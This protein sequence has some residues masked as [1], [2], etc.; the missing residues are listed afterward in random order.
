[1][2]RYHTRMFWTAILLVALTAVP[3]WAGPPTDQF[4]DGVDRVFKILRDPALKGE[5][6]ADRR[7]TAVAQVADDM[8]DFGESAKRS[9]G[10]ALGSENA[11]RTPGVRSPVHRVGPALVHLEGGSIRLREDDLSG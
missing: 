3:A 8:F 1:M 4:R 6:Q 10:A 9:L 2:A 7:I 11:C 5:A